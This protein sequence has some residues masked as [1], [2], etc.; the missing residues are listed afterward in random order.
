MSKKQNIHRGSHD[1][2]PI[3][4]PLAPQSVPLTNAVK[5]GMGM[6]HVALA[7]PMFRVPGPA[8]HSGKSKTVSTDMSVVS[9]SVTGVTG[10]GGKPPATPILTSGLQSSSS[11]PK[12]SLLQTPSDKGASNTIPNV[13]MNVSPQKTSGDA[14]VASPLSPD[15]PPF[16]KHSSVP[17]AW[18]A[19]PPP[20]VR[21]LNKQFT[22]IQ[23]PQ[24]SGLSVSTASL[25]VG[26]IDSPDPKSQNTELKRVDSPAQGHSSVSGTQID[27]FELTRTQASAAIQ[28]LPQPPTGTLSP[29]VEQE[30]K[31]V[32]VEMKDDE[33]QDPNVSQPDSS[34]SSLT[35]VRDTD[36]KRDEGPY[37]RLRSWIQP[38]AI[39]LPEVLQLG[40][41][42]ASNWERGKFPT[43]EAQQ[44]VIYHVLNKKLGKK[45]S[46]LSVSDARILPKSLPLQRLKPSFVVFTQSPEKKRE[47][48]DLLKAV[49]VTTR[50]FTPQMVDVESNTW[51]FDWD[52][53]DIRG[54][55]D[56]TVEGLQLNRI[57]YSNT[58]LHPGTIQFVV[59]KDSM[60]LL[61]TKVLHP[62]TK[63]PLNWVW[64]QPNSKKCCSNCWTAGHT[65]TSVPRPSG[66][67][68][69][70]A[71]SADTTARLV[72]VTSHV[73]SVE[74]STWP[75]AAWPTS[76]APGSP[77]RPPSSNH[78]ITHPPN[79]NQLNVTPTKLNHSL[80]LNLKLDPNLNP[81]QY[82]HLQQRPM[83]LKY[84]SKS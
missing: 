59:P 74:V 28:N 22:T 53:E 55:I 56:H 4:T 72:Q 47:L 64:K 10:G 17:S 32:D 7:M 20:I 6:D 30:E 57:N 63:E 82:N 69:V 8:D 62:I 33:A 67:T 68:G 13:T 23:P 24:T 25:Q 60:S 11:V 78:N 3:P 66:V 40:I 48:E 46:S 49:G 9:T 61:P 83:P 34:S 12:F 14:F 29:G 54:Y 51:P 27:D 19:A 71:P 70:L 35:G 75:H 81:H 45:I 26:K 79:L 76:S 43:P 77:F 52:E 73:P 38:N 16:K 80:H 50:P 15:Q 36:L 31:D 58:I 41:R 2:P 65:K 37:R 18:N 39:L 84:L 1:H 5:S 42:P 21:N 44:S